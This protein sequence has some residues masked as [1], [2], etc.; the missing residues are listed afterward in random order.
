MREKLKKILYVGSLEK[1][2]NSKKRFH[3][4]QKMGYQVEGIDIDPYIFRPFWLRFHYHL[5][6]G[7][8]IIAL[9][10]EVLNKIKD[11]K[12]D[13]LWVDNKPY[14][15]AW[16]LKSIRND[17][18]D[19]KIVNLITDDPF[20]SYSYC[21]KL[22]YHTFKYYDIHFVQRSIN[23]SEL[24]RKG[25]NRV[26]ICYRSFDPEFH[27]PLPEIQKLRNHQK[28]V[29]GFI[30]SYEEEREA[31]IAYLVRNG[32]H[33]EITG[34]GWT[35]GKEWNLL[36]DCYKGPS[37][38]GD[39]YVEAIN[40]MDIALHFLRKINRDQQDS[41]TFEIPACKVFMLAER[42][43]L[44]QELFTEGDEV[45]FFTSKEELLQKLKYYLANPELRLQ[46]AAAA[47]NRS[48]TS[49]YFHESRLN[50]VLDSIFDEQPKKKKIE[51]IVA[52]IYIDP[53]F[54]PPTINAII[55]LSEIS[56]EVVVVTRNHTAIDFP[57]PSNVRLVK[58]GKLMTVL[59]TEQ[60]SIF[61][62]FLSF[63]KFSFYLWKY[64]TKKHVSIAVLYDAI[65]L[66]SFFLIRKFISKKNIWYHNHDMPGTHMTRKFS[67]GWFSG[68]FEHSA[69]K[70]IHFFSLPSDDRLAFYPNWHQKNNYFSIPNYPS[71]KVYQ[72]T[73]PKSFINNEIRIIFQGTIGVEHAL[74]EI[75]GLLNKKIEGKS[76]RLIL[77][78]GVR[79][80]YKKQLTE[81]AQQL[82]VADKLEWVSLGPY[83]ELS[84]LTKSCHIG[85]AVYMG[86]DNVRK[87]LGTAS[88]KIYEYAASGLP[89][90]LFD[91][92]Q[93]RKYLSGYSWAYFTD[94]TP[95][96]LEK[97]ISEIVLNYPNASDSS[98]MSFEKTLNFETRFEKIKQRLEIEYNK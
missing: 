13:M 70:H 52:G 4:L 82:S 86:N 89:V 61:S 83:C 71:I 8:G 77:K 53:D 63:I 33:V 93:F 45:D 32:I 76:V 14:L 68:K 17:F 5:Y 11:L 88:N 96:S 41:R 3:T 87:T 67:I 48:F 51:S 31:H 80:Q 55:N 49:G 26:E 43:Y 20:G 56:E 2:G 9:N 94:G 81:L 72:R 23:I 97:C 98:R 21:W 91:N 15:K 95:A 85:V 90:I 62:K 60:M 7:P 27:R 36:K 75:I 64:I 28:T 34:N 30:G 69:M 19:M 79:P 58:L 16:A 92:E 37:V 35:E 84:S 29:V 10:K 66:F 65:P 73:T 42:S 54:Y 74:E 22:I 18:P 46:M 38:F 47:Y 50:K 25:A 24:K 78:G 44:H 40:R 57:Y 6:L 1:D 12:P 39:G 59:E